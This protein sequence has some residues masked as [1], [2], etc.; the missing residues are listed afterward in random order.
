M[1]KHLPNILSSA[2]IV[3]TIPLFFAEFLSPWFMTCLLVCGLSDVFDGIIARNHNAVTAFG[4]TLDSTADAIF[5]FAL[6]A[7]ILLAIA[8][9]VWIIIWLALILVIKGIALIAGLYRYHAMPFLHTY[10][11]KIVGILLFAFPF[12]LVL[13]FDAALTGGFLC[14]MATLASVE[15]CYLNLTV[16]E[17]DRDIAGIFAA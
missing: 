3:F 1:V 13:G 6:I 4:A 5:S 11:N 9:P 12:F 10:A 14:L 7:K 15:E 17:L 16:P 8:L 2:R